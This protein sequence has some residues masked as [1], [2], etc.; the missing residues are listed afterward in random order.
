M[1]PSLREIIEAKNNRLSTIPEK[2][3]S[4]VESTESVIYER[5][6]L[7][8]DKLKV[9]AEGNILRTK[10]NLVVADE[11]VVELNKVLYSSDY[12]NAL[13]SFAGQFDKQKVL[14]DKYFAKVFGDFASPDVAAMLV[15]YSKKQAVTL[16]TGSSVDVSFFKPINT[17]LTD[18]VAVGSSRVGMIKSIRETVIGSKNIDGRLLAHSKQIAHD[19][20]SLADR[21]Y[22]HAVA[23]E[24]DIEWFFYSGDTIDTSREFCVEKHNMYFHKKEIEAWASGTWDGKMKGTNKSTIFKTAGGY[25]CRH[26]ITPVSITM[27]PD[28]VIKRNIEKGNYKK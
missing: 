20:F 24:F 11:I 23:D 4:V 25:N 2:F 18:A 3:Y 13:A 15:D 22:T 1:Q 16:L 27:V 26:S 5:L 19:A 9:D 28:T 7:L 8:I 17:V 6:L 10:A 12:V 21:S 14:N